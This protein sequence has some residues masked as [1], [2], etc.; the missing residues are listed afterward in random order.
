VVSRSEI[1]PWMLFTTSCLFL[2]VNSLLDLA[3]RLHPGGIM[4]RRFEEAFG[5][6]R[7]GHRFRLPQL[8]TEVSPLSRGF[9]PA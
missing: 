4:C 2:R 5:S 1:L 6:T 9:L 8:N 3:R 7:Q